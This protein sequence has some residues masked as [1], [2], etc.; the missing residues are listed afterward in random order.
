MHVRGKSRTVK[1]YY[2]TQA[3]PKAYMG[4]TIPG[5]PNLYILGG[6]QAQFSVRNLRELIDVVPGPN[7][8]TGHTSVIFFQETQVHPARHP[9]FL[10]RF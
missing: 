9:E 7:T 6:L 10:V 2:D 1:E 4:T 8:A 5:F 3:G